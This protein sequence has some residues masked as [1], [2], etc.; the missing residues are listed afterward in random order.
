STSVGRSFRP[1]TTISSSSR[2]TT[3]YSNDTNKT[4][5]RRGTPR[6]PRRH[7]PTPGK[8]R[9]SA[10][11]R[12]E[13]REAGSERAL[14]AVSRLSHERLRTSC[15]RHAEGHLLSKKTHKDATL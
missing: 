14:H 1:N 4:S 13:A 10:P 9:G 7:P 5:G 6:L 11:T 3:T 8:R 2:H 12:E 15:P